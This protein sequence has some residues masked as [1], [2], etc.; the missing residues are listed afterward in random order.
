MTEFL[1]QPIEKIRQV[2]NKLVAEQVALCA[3]GHEYYKRCW[4]EHGIDTSKEKTIDD[5]ELLPL[6]PK[7][8]LMNDPEA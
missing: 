1:R 7:Q 8:D 6:T 4:T 5:L 3:E 2:Q